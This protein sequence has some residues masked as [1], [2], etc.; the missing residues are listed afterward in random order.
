MSLS[1]LEAIDRR[2]SRRTYIPVPLD[3]AVI[4]ELEALIAACREAEGVD[5]RLVVGQPAAFASFTKSYGMFKGVQNYIALIEHTNEEH[6]IEKLGYYGE[7]MILHATAMGLGSCWVGGTFSRDACPFTLTPSQ[8]ILCTLTLGSTP[9]APTGKEKFI[10][11]LTHR[12][13][14]T[15]AQMACVEGAVPPWF[16]SGME[17]VAKAPSSLNRQPVVFT[18][19]D[20]AVTAAVADLQNA[21]AVTD[22]GIAKL[23]FT[24]GAGGGSWQW[25]NGGAFTPANP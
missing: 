3:T 8:H 12:K 16:W 11:T 15:A 1:L 23:H 17:A 19:R 20:G 22:M 14:K 5:M 18:C 25:G 6:S 7:Q 9:D 2:I 4:K 24:L 13:A 10:R 21:G